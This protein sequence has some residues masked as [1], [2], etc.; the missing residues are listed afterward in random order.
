MI[1]VW[2]QTLRRRPRGPYPWLQRW[3]A[4]RWSSLLSTFR[5]WRLP[6]ERHCLQRR[7]VGPSTCRRADDVVGM[8]QRVRTRALP[9]RITPP[10]PGRRSS[11]SPAHLGRLVTVRG[12][13]VE[14]REAILPPDGCDIDV[15][16]GY[17]QPCTSASPYG[18]MR[19]V[20]HAAAHMTILS[21]RS[22]ASTGPGG[23]KA[24]SRPN[25]GE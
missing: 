4:S 18:P 8:R 17:R 16:H 23:G 15:V 12:P 20:S 1:S 24:S 10:P 2:V 9:H 7:D 22:P 6:S 11:T 3:C 25:L 13:Y 5:D 21:N 14:D 19:G